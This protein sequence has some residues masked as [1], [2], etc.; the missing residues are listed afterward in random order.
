MHAP[1]LLSICRVE[2]HTAVVSRIENWCCS[3]CEITYH[4]YRICHG[5]L[6]FNNPDQDPEF[7]VRDLATITHNIPS[8][9]FVSPEA[10]GESS[11]FTFYSRSIRMRVYTQHQCSFVLRQLI[12]LSSVFHIQANTIPVHRLAPMTNDRV[13]TS[14][15]H[16]CTRK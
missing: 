2:P 1:G 4:V 9:T 11:M 10:L 8:S 13:R 5:E 16:T 6:R 15:Q 7:R 14:L 12:I 3:I